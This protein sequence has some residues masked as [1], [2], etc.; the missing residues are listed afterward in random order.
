MAKKAKLRDVQVNCTGWVFDQP[1]IMKATV[2]RVVKNKRGTIKGYVCELR[3]ENGAFLGEGMFDRH[4]FY[5]AP[6]EITRLVDA[7]H[8]A[9]SELVYDLKIFSAVLGSELKQ[10]HPDDEQTVAKGVH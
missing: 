7:I 4:Q 3:A 2:T 6:D 10:S 9:I 8:D 5:H 1:A